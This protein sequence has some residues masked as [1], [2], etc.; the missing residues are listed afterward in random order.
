MYEELIQNSKKT[1][2]REIS[3]AIAWTSA[4]FK[5]QKHQRR[6]THGL[7][8]NTDSD[9]VGYADFS[10]PENTSSL[11]IRIII[12]YGPTNPSSINNP[13]IRDQFYDSLTRAWNSTTQRTLK[14]YVGDFNSKVGHQANSSVG[15]FSKGQRNENGDALVQWASSHQLVL[16]NTL[17]RYS[18]RH[19]TT[20][21]GHIQDKT[22]GSTRKIYNMIDFILV[23]DHCKP[24]V[25]RARSFGGTELFSDHKLVIADIETSRLYRIFNTHST[26]KPNR[27]APL[28]VDSLRDES[29]REIYQKEVVSKMNTM[30]STS[31]VD[32][33][34]NTLQAAHNAAEVAVGRMHRSRSGKFVKSNATIQSLSIEQRNLRLLIQSDRDS[35]GELRKKRNKLS[36]QIRRIQREE[37]AKQLDQL[38]E[39]VGHA[40]DSVK[41]FKAAKA[42]KKEKKRPVTV[43][44]SDGST[45]ARDVDKVSAIQDHFRSQFTSESAIPIAQPQP[46]RLQDPVTK[47]EVNVALKRLNNKKASGTDNTP[48]ELL[49]YGGDSV[50]VSITQFMNTGIAN[51]EDLSPIIGAGQLIPL[52]KPNK[53]RG[54]LTSLRPI[55]LLN[56]IRKVFSLVVLKRIYSSVTTFLGSIPSGFR[57]GRST[58]DVI[59]TQRWIAAKAER[60]H[61][62]CHLLG[63]DMSRAFDTIDRTRLMDVMRRIVKL[64]E[65]VMIHHLLFNTAIQVRLGNSTSTS[66]VSTIGTPQGDSL[67]PVLFVCYLEA[68]LQFHMRLAMQMTLHCTQQASRG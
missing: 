53:P 18:M 22:T 48:A 52:A 26:A 37:A 61:W 17:F 30:D 11:D 65:L 46:H 3:P 60:Y 34:N 19:R 31:A 49:K 15:N 23:P 27:Y 63:I 4:D 68:A 13:D 44:S 20:W 40:P 57:H 58:A 14:F 29:C 1:N 47:M 36:R 21:T 12:A 66:F 54:P 59:W 8:I 43:Q 5:R 32:T 28:A 42:L 55:V 35:N 25:K 41:M 6:M 24:L 16:C 38:A 50:P 2:S 33:W 10:I 45:L 62:D 64:D 51:G 39:D 67:S 7:A 9:R 56:T